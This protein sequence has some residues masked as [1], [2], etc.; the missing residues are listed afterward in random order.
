MTDEQF[1]EDGT[2]GD[3]FFSSLAANPDDPA[4]L[5]DTG[6]DPEAGEDDYHFLY[7]SEGDGSFE[8]DGEGF[9]DDFD[10]E[11]FDD[12]DYGYD[13]DTDFDPGA[14]A[15]VDIEPDFD[16]DGDLVDEGDRE[17]GIDSGFGL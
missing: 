9:G 14:D 11:D 10:D 5:Y 3:D 1:D 6:L 2:F 7:E 8:T 17:F 4:S 16:P 12:A 15:E 13:A